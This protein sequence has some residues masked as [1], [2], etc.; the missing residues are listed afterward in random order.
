[1]YK[2]DKAYTRIPDNETPFSSTFTAIY[3]LFLFYCLLSDIFIN[4]KRILISELS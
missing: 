1:M 2:I 3:K 4:F